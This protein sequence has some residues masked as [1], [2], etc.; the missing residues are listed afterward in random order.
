MSEL[1]PCPFC[2]G[3]VN[4]FLGNNNNTGVIECRCGAGFDPGGGVDDIV[5]LWNSRTADDRLDKLEA[6]YRAV[7]IQERNKPSTLSCPGITNGVAK[8]LAAYEKA[9][10]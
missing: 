4:L 8:A 10:S 5:S 2:N 3:K 7:K 1:K 6:L 9:I